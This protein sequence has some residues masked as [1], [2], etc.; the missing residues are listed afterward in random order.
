MWEAALSE[1]TSKLNYS[2]ILKG[3]IVQYRNLKEKRVPVKD[4]N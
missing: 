4:I 2:V 3:E 1:V